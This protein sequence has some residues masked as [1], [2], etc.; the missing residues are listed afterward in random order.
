MNANRISAIHHITA[1][2]SSAAENVAFYERV[3]GLRLVKQTVNFDDPYTYHLYYGDGAGSPG[4]ILTFFPWEGIPQRQAR[5]GDD[6]RSCLLGSAQ[7]DGVLAR[8][9]EIQR[10]R[11]SGSSHVSVSP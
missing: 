9:T 8:E 3:L 11:L 1:I 7:L 6:R 2:A 5:F 10:Y 4:T